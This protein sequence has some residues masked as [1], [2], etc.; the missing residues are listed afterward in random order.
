MSLILHSFA[1]NLSSFWSITRIITCLQQLFNEDIRLPSSQRRYLAGKYNANA[2]RIL[3]HLFHFLAWKHQM[4]SN[5]SQAAHPTDVVRGCPPIV[6]LRQEHTMRSSWQLQLFK[7]PLGS[8]VVKEEMKLQHGC[9]L[10]ICDSGYS[11]SHKWCLPISNGTQG[12]ATRFELEGRTGGCWNPGYAL[13]CERNVFQEQR[14]SNQY[15]NQAIEQQILNQSV[16]P[17]RPWVHTAWT[18]LLWA[19][20]LLPTSKSCCVS[21]GSSTEGT[22]SLKTSF[23]LWPLCKEQQIDSFLGLAVFCSAHTSWH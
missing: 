3:L 15:V 10:V 16:K 18:T 4:Y 20:H 13:I 2:V 9:Q 5:K 22:L 11:G 19:L 12:A 14:K 8:A 1:R 6:R 21:I 17:T 23:S 7:P